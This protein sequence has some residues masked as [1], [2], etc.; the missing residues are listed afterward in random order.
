MSRLMYEYKEGDLVAIDICP[1][2]ISTAPHRRYQGKVGVVV[3][4]RGR[5]Y[6]VKIKVGGKEK[7]IITTKDHIRPF[8]AQSQQIQPQ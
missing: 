3:G 5:A 7:L 2:Y 6:L 8:V 1:N 4:R